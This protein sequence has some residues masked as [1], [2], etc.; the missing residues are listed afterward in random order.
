M[1]H[2]IEHD[3]IYTMDY[4]VEC[5]LLPISPNTFGAVTI[6]S[7]T[8]KVCISAS[9]EEDCKELQEIIPFLL[10]LEES[11]RNGKIL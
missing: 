10:D 1:I 5:K 2:Y 8:H 11:I 7:K 6:N 4:D 3:R 9:D